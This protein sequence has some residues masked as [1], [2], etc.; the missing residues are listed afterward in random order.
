MPVT[1][2][3]APRE[4]QLLPEPRSPRTGKKRKEKKKNCRGRTDPPRSG[5]RGLRAPLHRYVHE[6]DRIHYIPWLIP[7]A[8]SR[9]EITKITESTSPPRK[10]RWINLRCFTLRCPNAVVLT[11]TS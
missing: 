8:S 2:Y 5:S 6:H 7:R 11:T 4:P 1:D 10:Y 9:V 3:A